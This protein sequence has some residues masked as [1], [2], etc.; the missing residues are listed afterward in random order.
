MFFP[1]PDMGAHNLKKKLYVV[2]ISGGNTYI[3]EYT[4]T[5][6]TNSKYMHTNGK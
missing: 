5:K 3:E 6:L 1:N 2:F 4:L